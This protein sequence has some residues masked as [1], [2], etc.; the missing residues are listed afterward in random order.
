MSI[1]DVQVII[2][3]PLRPLTEVTVTYEDEVRGQHVTVERHVTYEVSCD[4]CG[5]AIA[6]LDR[7]PEAVEQMTATHDCEVES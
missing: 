7:F 4:D 1:L 2:R 6:Q 3:T 5:D